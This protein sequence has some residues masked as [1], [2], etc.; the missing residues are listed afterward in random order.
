MKIL[1]LIDSLGVGGAE[2]HV[3]TLASELV[4]RGHLVYIGSCGGELSTDCL[5]DGAHLLPLPKA[6]PMD[7]SRIFGGVQSLMTL[8]AT[9]HMIIKRLTRLRPDIVHAHTRRMAFLVST[10]CKRLGIPLVT[11]AHALFSAKG[12]RAML[13]RWG[14]S[15]IAVSEDIAEHLVYRY[16][17]SQNK[18]TVIP[19]GVAIPHKKTKNPT[20]KREW[21]RKSD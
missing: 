7:N 1:M 8:L 19:N 20:P 14:D 13:S 15:T 11:T 4:K 10:P 18:I 16:A 5:R 17:L 2:T 12:I 3:C 21:D 6:T 9:K